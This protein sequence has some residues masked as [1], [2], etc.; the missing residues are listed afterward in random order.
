MRRASG[1]RGH[2]VGWLLG[3]ALLAGAGA[4]PATTLQDLADGATLTS[5]DGTL[6]FDNFQVSIAGSG[7]SQD[8][9]DYNVVVLDDGFAI[10]GPIGVA[11]GFAG[12]INLE[13][14]VWALGDAGVVGASLSM[15]GAADLHALAS[16][17]DIYS[18][19]S[20][21]APPDAEDGG[22]NHGWDGNPGKHSR[23]WHSKRWGG[24]WWSSK[25]GE[26]DGWPYGRNHGHGNGHE[27]SKDCEPPKSPLAGSLFVR[28]VG[29]GN[30]ILFDELGFPEVFMHLHTSKDILVTAVASDGAANISRVE[31]RY[32]VVPE[33]ATALLLGGGLAALALRRRRP[34]PGGVR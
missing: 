30:P 29:D 14:D 3:L 31:Q 2:W 12:D 34:R 19:F 1:A 13:Y 8:A 20:D 17:T 33:P 23:R 25:P 4:A 5:G 11:P 10:T 7:I 15:N 21:S 26:F 16:V 22:W 9:S 32:T 28:D 27:D 24:D 6:R 18:T